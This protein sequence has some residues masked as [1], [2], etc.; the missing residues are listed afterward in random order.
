MLL[1]AGC[2]Q[3]QDVS[4]EVKDTL[5]QAG[6]NR[7]ALF[8]VIQHYA[9]PADSLK[10]EA[11]FFLIGNMKDKYFFDSEELDAYYHFIDSLFQIRQKEYDIPYLRDVFVKQTGIDFHTFNP[12]AHWDSQYISDSILI[13]NIDKAFSVWDK[14]WNRHLSF[15]DFCEY[16]LPY[17]VS[18]ER[19]ELWRTLYSQKYKAVLSD[20]IHKFASFKPYSVTFR[21]VS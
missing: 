4:D 6:N 10:R 12:G 20:S 11:A 3:W 17:R 18:R 15:A 5:T 14:P 16:L 19:P 13:D 21:Y 1:L 9:Q 8:K 7:E 2:K